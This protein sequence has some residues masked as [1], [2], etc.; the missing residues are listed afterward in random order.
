[1]TC[2]TGLI[3]SI[4]NLYKLMIRDQFETKILHFSYILKDS[5]IGSGCNTGQ[6]IA[7][8]PDVCVGCKPGWSLTK[9]VWKN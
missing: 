6:N 1:M 3:Q 2:F 4:L 9:M 8:G 5:S 7:V